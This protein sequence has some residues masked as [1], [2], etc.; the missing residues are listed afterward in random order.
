MS[1]I[2]HYYSST[3]FNEAGCLSSG[4]Q[5][6]SFPILLIPLVSLLRDPLSLPAETR[7]SKWVTIATCMYEVSRVL[8]LDFRSKLFNC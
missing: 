8:T 2:I 7:I 4:D 6:Q 1:K 5:L 3:A